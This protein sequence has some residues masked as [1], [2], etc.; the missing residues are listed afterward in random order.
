MFTGYITAEVSMQVHRH[1][2]YD[3]LAAATMTCETL[4]AAFR[5]SGLQRE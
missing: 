4:D 2:D 3:L 5:E 1:P